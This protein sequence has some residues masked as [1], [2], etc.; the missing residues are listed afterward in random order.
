MC[1]ESGDTRRVIGKRG[2][3]SCLPLRNITAGITN[4]HDLVALDCCDVKLPGGGGRKCIWPLVALCAA[5]C[6]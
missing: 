3:L 6:L 2:L 4:N 5:P 1:R